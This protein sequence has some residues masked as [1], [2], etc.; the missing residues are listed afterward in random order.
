MTYDTID[1][2][3]AFSN[4]RQPHY[5][6]SD[7]DGQTIKSV[8]LLKDVLI[9]LNKLIDLAPLTF[10]TGDSVVLYPACFTVK[11]VELTPEEVVQEF[12]LHNP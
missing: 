6:Y 3:P 5:I 4:C 12:T 2:S 1:N 8:L 11:N 9:N 10:T 7:N